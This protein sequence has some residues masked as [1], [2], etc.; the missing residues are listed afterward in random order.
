MKKEK[1]RIIHYVRVST[2][3]QK[4][5]RQETSIVMGAEVY[6]D[7][8]SGSVP[9][10]KRDFG[11]VLM[12]EV[13]AGTIDEVHVHSIDRLG[14]NTLDI[15]NT[16]QFFTENGVNLISKKEGLQTLNE[17]G[18]E[19]IT[20]KLLVGIL[21]TLAEFERSRIKERQAEGIAKAKEKGTYKNRP[22]T[23]GRT[24]ENDKQI[25][26]KYKKTIVK[27]LKNGESVRRTAKVCGVST[28]TVTKV[29]K[30]LYNTTGG[31][32]TI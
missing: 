13:E 7:K 14:R 20:A 16:I 30:A 24:A 9:F 5:D 18:S 23:G 25:I 11:Q 17:D 28:A 22:K 12:H 3:E 10:E 27:E 1:K 4:T 26:E 31:N 21:G 8:C 6:T 15:M 19:N 29:K 2:L 32:Y